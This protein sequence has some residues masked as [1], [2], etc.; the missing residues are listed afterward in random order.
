MR[1]SKLQL[2]YNVKICYC[3]RN[4]DSVSQPARENAL[5]VCYQV[6]LTEHFYKKKW[7]QWKLLGQFSNM[8]EFLYFTNIMKEWINNTSRWSCF[9]I[10]QKAPHKLKE[11]LLLGLPEILRPGSTSGPGSWCHSSAQVRPGSHNKIWQ[12][13]LV[14]THYITV[15][16][17]I[18]NSAIFVSE[19][20]I[21][22]LFM[23]TVLIPAWDRTN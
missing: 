21:A 7:Q 5:E 19:L 23:A 9:Q 20:K 11:V 6:K 15:I 16:T 18:Q 14:H 12:V 3:V 10:L 17:P 2:L 8:R 1:K 4:L 13:F 22:Q